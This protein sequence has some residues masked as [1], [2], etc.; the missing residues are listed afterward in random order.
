[1]KKDLKTPVPSKLIEI[2]SLAKTWK[3]TKN[4]RTINSPAKQT[5]FRK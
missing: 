3:R 1:M 2:F 5:A 4:V